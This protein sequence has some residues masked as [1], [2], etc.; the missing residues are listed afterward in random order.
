MGKITL[1]GI[2]SEIAKSGANKGKILY[3]KEGVQYRVRFLTDFEDGIEVPFHDSF[4]LSVN[5]PCQEIFGRE[6]P[7][8]DNS[9]LRTRS[10]YCWAVYD[11]ESKEVKL[12]LEAVNQC[13]CVGA[14]SAYYETHGTLTDRDYIIKQLGGGTNKQF[15]VIGQEK[16]I[17]RNS[18]VKPLTEKAMLKIIDKAFPC[19]DAAGESEEEEEAETKIPEWNEKMKPSQLY[20]ICQEREIEVQPRQPKAY[21]TEK[22]EQDD[23]ER[24]FAQENEEEDEWGEEQEEERQDYTKMK[25]IE[26]FKLC[27]EKGIECEAKKPQ[28]YYIDL[29]DAA[30]EWGE[31][32]DE[33][34]E[35]DFMN[36]PDGVDEELPFN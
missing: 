2:K 16:R 32:E 17:F 3:F 23:E 6:C 28:K 31:E 13:T 14:L 25:P 10:K 12:L 8:C 19:E 34:G 21:Y 1:A 20:K 4:K 33:W 30:D 9:D 36:I 26:L 22:L 11:Y 15:T 18:K 24:L 7:G 35:D 29:L 5:Y 27:K